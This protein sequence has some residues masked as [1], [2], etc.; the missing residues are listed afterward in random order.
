M[1]IKIKDSIIRFQRRNKQ[2]AVD[3][4]GGGCQKCGYN[5]CIDA[6][7][8]HHLDKLKKE[9]TPSYVINSC[10]LKNAMKELSKC[11][12]LCANC[13]RE[14]H[15]NNIDLTYVSIEKDFISKECKYCHTFFMTKT[16]DQVYCSVAC[17]GKESRKVV[18]PSKTELKSLIKKHNWVNLGKMFGVSDNAV[19]KWAKKYE[20]L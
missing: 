16:Y 9:F 19:R 10:S 2:S 18:R 3:I 4:F 7:E 14:S 15:S 17:R 12:L 20:L 1:S 13:H 8:F 5:K 11:V 6:L